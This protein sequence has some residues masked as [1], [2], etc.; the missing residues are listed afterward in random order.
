MKEIVS[1]VEFGQR[2]MT[3]NDIQLPR[4]G[5]V[6]KLLEIRGDPIIIAGQSYAAG[7]ALYAIDPAAYGA[8][9]A[10]IKE[11]RNC[12]EDLK[13]KYPG[14]LQPEIVHIGFIHFDESVYLKTVYA[15]GE[16][17][18]T[19]TDF[20]FGA[21][22]RY[23]SRLRSPD[24]NVELLVNQFDPVSIINCFDFF[25]MAAANQVN[26]EWLASQEDQPAAPLPNGGARGALPG[27]SPA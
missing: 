16:V 17:T 8:V 19:D 24:D 18:L 23:F 12:M 22:G 4:N 15:G 7:Q 11:S 26:A 1:K 10:A 21:E 3:S 5:T 6:D 14:C 27:A 25:T 20:I 2:P 9:A 13:K